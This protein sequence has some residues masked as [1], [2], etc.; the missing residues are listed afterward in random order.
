M[1]FETSSRP[2]KCS[3]ET[4]VAYNLERFYRIAQGKL[5]RAEAQVRKEPAKA[6]AYAVGA[7]YLLSLLHLGSIS[8]ALARLAAAA[9]WPAVIL[10]GA[11][12]LLMF[13]GF[14]ANRPAGGV[15]S[16]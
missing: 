15:E 10:Y 14:S 11:A 16:R 5:Q 2:G 12:K 13:L 7:G 8:K 4:A 9:L 6:M 1:N 3:L